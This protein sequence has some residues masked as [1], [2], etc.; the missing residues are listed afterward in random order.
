MFGQHKG[1]FYWIETSP[2][3]SLCASEGGEGGGRNFCCFGL[4]KVAGNLSEGQKMKMTFAKRISLFSS[5]TPT[6][7][8]RRILAPRLGFANDHRGLSTQSLDCEPLGLSL[9]M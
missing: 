3:K 1:S 7:A 8:F 9:V 5:N 4:V 2:R 6:S